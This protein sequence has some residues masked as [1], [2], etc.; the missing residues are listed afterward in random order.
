MTR[1]L[2]RLGHRGAFND[3]RAVRWPGRNGASNTA[4][5]SS[6]QLCSSANVALPANIAFSLLGECRDSGGSDTF[7]RQ[8]AMATEATDQL[9]QLEQ[10]KA[11]YE[12]E[13]EALTKAMPVDVACKE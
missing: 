7:A 3:S 9:R 1:L 6:R 2:R 11:K 5:S 8:P 10:D 12:A 13:L 4:K